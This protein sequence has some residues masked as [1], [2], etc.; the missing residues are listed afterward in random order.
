MNNTNNLINI[1]LQQMS[2][3]LDSVTGKLNNLDISIQKVNHSLNLVGNAFQSASEKCTGFI[4]NLTQIS[5]KAI[6][7]LALALADLYT[8]Q[9]SLTLES[10]VTITTFIQQQNAVNGLNSD[11]LTVAN[12]MSGFMDIINNILTPAAA[13]FTILGNA[14][15]VLAMLSKLANGYVL[16]GAAIAAGIAL[17]VTAYN[18][19][20]ELRYVVNESMK[21]ILK[22]LPGVGVFATSILGV[23]T[24]INKFEGFRKVA[25]KTKDGVTNTFDK[26]GACFKDLFTSNKEVADSNNEMANSFKNLGSAQRTIIATTLKLSKAQN[27]NLETIGGVKQKIAELKK[28]Q[29]SASIDQAKAL[30]KEIKLWQEK[31][32]AMNNAVRLSTVT[33]PELATI[34]P[35]SI[36]P[37]KVELDL[38]KENT[39]LQQFVSNVSTSEKAIASLKKVTIDLSNQLQNAATNVLG[40]FGE[41]LGESLAEGD[42]NSA[43]NALLGS[44]LDSLQAFGGALIAAGTAGLALQTIFANPILAIGAG[45][46]LIAATSAAKAALQ[47]AAKPMA[48]GGIAYGT[49][50]AMV[51]EYPGAANNPEVVAPLNKLRQLIQPAGEAGGTYEFR[52]RGRDFVAVAAKYNQINNRTR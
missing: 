24:L 37:G 14:E 51:G 19:Y 36:N 12:S 4:Q 3:S 2:I 5:T 25:D 41:A 34:A 30:Q 15:T 17:S 18:K 48:N 22:S 6:D 13:L 35:K 49:T 10:T 26:I 40:N 7:E 43:F 33:P 23:E 42:L 32:D 46:A 8:A 11:I 27:N 50:F 28:E 1:G 16:I 39:A 9:D 45:V 38:D 29:E 52:L 31:L 47:N 21:I 20:E 44:V